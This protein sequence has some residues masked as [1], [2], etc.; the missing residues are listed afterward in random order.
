MSFAMIEESAINEKIKEIKKELRLA[1]NGVVSSIQRNHGLNYKINFGVEIPRLKAIA[2]KFEK[3]KELAKRLWQDNIR[4]CK[5]LAIFLM[6][7]EHYKDIAEEWI[8]EAPFTE[9]ADHLTM[10]ILSKLPEAATKALEWI[11]NDEGMYRYCGFMTLTHLFRRGVELDKEQ[12][13]K[14]LATAKNIEEVDS[15]KTVIM[16]AYN[17][18]GHYCNEE[19]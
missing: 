4:E 11:Q 9:I 1:M 19:E 10:V 3:N 8:K 13:C 6:P 5:I 7:D 12:E 16:A 18:L 2:G 17:S 14:Y 15:R